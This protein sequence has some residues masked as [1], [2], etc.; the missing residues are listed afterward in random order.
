MPSNWQ[1]IQDYYAFCKEPN[2]SDKDKKERFFRYFSVYTLEKVPCPEKNETFYRV[3]KRYVLHLT[4]TIQG[5]GWEA[6]PNINS[7]LWRVAAL[8]TMSKW[9]EKYPNSVIK[10][11]LE[12]SDVK[13]ML[14]FLVLYWL[15]HV[16]TYKPQVY[17]NL[18]HSAEHLI[19]HKLTM[20]YAHSDSRAD[21]FIRANSSVFFFKNTKLEPLVDVN[22]EHAWNLEVLPNL[23]L[24]DLQRSWAEYRQKCQL[25]VADANRFKNMLGPNADTTLDRQLIYCEATK[26]VD[27][28]DNHVKQTWKRNPKLLNILKREWSKIKSPFFKPPYFNISTIVLIFKELSKEHPVSR[29]KLKIASRLVDS[30]IAYLNHPERSYPLRETLQLVSSAYWLALDTAEILAFFTELQHKWHPLNLSNISSDDWITM[31]ISDTILKNDIQYRVGF[32]NKSAQVSI[33][34]LSTGWQYMLATKE[35][36]NFFRTHVDSYF[37]EYALTCIFAVMN[38]PVPCAS[39]FANNRARPFKNPVFDF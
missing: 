23:Q 7:E 24:N 32:P 15:D 27:P 26:R 14:P 9:Y 28:V 1:L 2:R 6:L 33:G 30:H 22:S 16:K 20:N 4:Q 25:T 12:A 31:R 39:H 29:S 11:I 38:Q 18:C 13:S 37:Y 5:T 19:L 10:S 36:V 35:L 34:S 3:W 8:L 17:A 21:S